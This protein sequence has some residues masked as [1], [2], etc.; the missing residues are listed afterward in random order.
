MNRDAPPPYTKMAPQD[1]PL[2]DCEAGTQ[3]SASGPGRQP[4]RHPPMTYNYSSADGA[5]IRFPVG[6][7]SHP[8]CEWHGCGKREGCGQYEGCGKFDGCGKCE[9][10]GGCACFMPI[11]NGCEMNWASIMVLLAF[12]AIILVVW[13]LFKKA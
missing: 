1:I 2:D 13:F 7:N 4:L 6:D 12:F 5:S 9:G 10:C 8:L 3:T 11:C